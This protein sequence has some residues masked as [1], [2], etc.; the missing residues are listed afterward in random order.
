MKTTISLLAAGV[1]LAM[2]SAASPA[3]PGKEDDSA[4]KWGRWA[5]LSPA[6][7]Q[8]EPVARL[9]PQAANNARPGEADPFD[10]KVQDSPSGD[11]LPAS[12]CTAGANCGYATYYPGP[13]DSLQPTAAIPGYDQSDS[14]PPGPVL[15]QFGLQ[16]GIGGDTEGSGG[17]STRFQVSGTNDPDYPDL[18]SVGMDSFGNSSFGVESGQTVSSLDNG[19]VSRTR[20]RNQSAIVEFGNRL[21]DTG[22]WTHEAR[23]QTTLTFP[24]PRNGQL[25]QRT[26]GTLAGHGFFAYGS[27]PTLQEMERFMSRNAVAEYRGSVLDFNSSMSMRFN[28]RDNSVVGRFASENGFNGFTATGRVNGGNFAARDGANG[29]VGSFFAGGENVSGAV[30]NAT[31]LGVFSADRVVSGSGLE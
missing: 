21:A 28:F 30:K 6:A 14:E 24:E 15:A 4:Y 12:Y 8:R 23:S 29:F 10:P 27:T 19:D 5:V 2:G 17:A 9:T 31:Q 20:Y 1:I 25:A 13:G 18:N 3:A 7:G 22:T 16:R 26:D 11:T